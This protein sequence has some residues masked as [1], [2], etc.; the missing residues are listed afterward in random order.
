MNIQRLQKGLA[1]NAYGG[2][3]ND[4]RK[5]RTGITGRN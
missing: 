5:K 1:Y 4:R 2:G 3:K